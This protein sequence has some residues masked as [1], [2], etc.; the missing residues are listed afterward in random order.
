M[1]VLTPDEIDFLAKKDRQRKK[2][3]EAQALYR[4]KVNKHQEEIKDYNKSIMKMNTLN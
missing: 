1:N 3:A 4:T 2:H